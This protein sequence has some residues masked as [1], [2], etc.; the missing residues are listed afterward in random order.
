MCGDSLALLS[1]WE[2][3]DT[4]SGSAIGNVHLRCKPDSSFMLQT[5]GR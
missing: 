1:R 3:N 2:T 4:D 5:L